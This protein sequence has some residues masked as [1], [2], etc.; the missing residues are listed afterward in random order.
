M[1][2]GLLFIG[3]FAATL[4]SLHSFGSYVRL[5]GYAL[6]LI[7]SLKLRKYNRAFTFLTVS[8][9][10]ML[11]VSLL[12]AVGDTWEFLYN[13]LILD[14]NVF[15]EAFRLNVGYVEM[16]VSF[17]LN[18]TMLFAIRSIAVETDA[19]K[20]PENAV[21]NFV[22]VCIYYVL[23]VL[24][25]LPVDILKDF[26]KYFGA[27]TL[28]L[29]FAWII[30]NAVLIYSCYMN[31]CDENDVDMEIKPSRFA[32]VNNMRA[33]SEMRKQ[34]LESQRQELKEIREKRKG[35]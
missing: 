25:V 5:L 13:M 14:T 24:Q 17:I 29:Y 20:I 31:I 7:S 3:Y 8:T 1:G 23:Y 11:V 10:L 21:R 6:V 12:L 27:P 9:V 34:S 15:S 30:L 16:A 22:F 26:G 2:F 19:E 18:G 28:L 35:K 33:K 4:M 32:F